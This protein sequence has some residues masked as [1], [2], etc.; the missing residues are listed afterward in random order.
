MNAG[1]YQITASGQSAQN[2][3]IS[4]Q[5]G[6]LTVGQAALTVTANNAGKTYDGLAFSGGNGVSYSGF[7]NGETAA[8]LA[9][10]IAYG[11]NAQ[12]AVNAG[13]YQITASGQSA[14]NYAIS[15]QPGTLTV[16]QVALTV[17]ANNAGKTYDGLAF[18]G[19]NGVSYSGFVNG[20]TATVLTGNIA[21]GGN[22]QGAVNA[23]GYQITAS[24]QSAQ[25][26]AISYQPGTLT[27]NQA[28]LTVTANNA[29][30]TY[31][32]LAFSGGNGVSYSGFVNGETAAVLAGTIAYAG[33]A[34]GA[35]NAG[36]YQI[37]ASGQSA[38]NYAISYQP[39]TLTVN[40]AALTVTAN[41]AGKTY[42][43]LAFSGGNGVSYSGFVNGETATVLAGTIAYAGNAQGAVN[44]GGY[45]I[46]ASGQSAQNYAISYQPGTLTVNQAALT[47]TA[48]NA[49]KTYDGLAFSGGNGVSYSGFVNGETAT[50][51]TGNI[52]YGGSAQGA[53]NAGGYQIT[54]SGQ[55]A[56][57]YAI[58]YQPGTLT[59]NQAA[60]TV[61]ANNAGKTYDG[62]AFSGGNGVSYSGFVNGE[63]AT[64]LAGT[65]AYAGNAQGAVNAGGYQITASGQSAQNYAISYQP[66]TLT[67]NQ[68]ALTV[69][70][71]NAGKTYDGLAFSGGNGVSYSGFVNGETATVLAGTIAYAGNAQGAVN[72]GGYQITASGQSAQNYAISYQPGTLTVNPAPVTVTALGGSS[73]YGGSPSDPGF[74]ATGLQNGQGVGALTGLGNSFGITNLTNAGGYVLNVA[75]TLTNPNYIVTVTNPGTWVVNP[76]TLTYVAN[77]AIAP[78]GA[79]IPTLG[80]VVVGFVNGDSL[81]AVAIGSPSFVTP[82]P[83]NAPGGIYP[84]D[85]QGL[86]VISSNY[87]LVQAPTNATALTINPGGNI[88]NTPTTEAQVLQNLIQNISLTPP[89]G[90]V[91]NIQPLT[92]PP[93]GRPGSGPPSAPGGLPPQFGARFFVPPELGAAH[94]DNEV[95][96]QIPNNIPA[97]QLQAMMRRLGLSILGSQSLGLLGVTSYWVHI[98]NGASIA[99][100]I[101]ALAGYQIVAGAQANYTYVLTQGQSLAQGQEPD[102]ASLSQGEGDAAQYTISK[103]GLIDVHRQLKGGNISVAVIDSQ[104]DVKHPDL[105][106]VVAEQFDAVGAADMPH[107]H[108]TGMAGAI[109]AHRKLMGVAP[110][111]RLYAIHAFSSGATSA[112]STTF[113]ILKGLEWASAKGV[114]VIN[115]SFAGPRDPSMERA[116]KAAHDKGIVLIAAAGNAGPKS[117]PLYPGADPNVI[118]V[119]AT[120]VND[121]LFTGA[122]RGRYIAVAA[123][124]VDILVPAPDNTY[125][126]TTGTSVASAE[127]SGLVALLLERNPNLGPEEVRK[128]LTSSA[129]RLSAKDRDDDFGSGLV[130]PSKAIQTAGDLTSVEM[131]GTVPPQPP[132][133]RPF[134]PARPAILSQPGGSG[135]RPMPTR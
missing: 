19:G 18:S 115:M 15:Y 45:Q 55:S 121:K 59:V 77:P 13:G 61:T 97:A 79:S 41:N 110:S 53:V 126:L 98:D 31:D 39:G 69:T 22:S 6:T 105:D 76:A 94:K 25:N 111:A 51:L 72:A 103:L 106:G 71:N 27:V 5:P 10:T 16:N 24:G 114:R 123:P 37:T 30:K 75:G 117:P 8:V 116:L 92:Q 40:Q 1:G 93:P 74:T 118:A 50:V 130:D 46:T 17:T 124:G 84:I 104:I 122:N 32:G 100:V 29:G 63:T 107:S 33:N 86:T 12:G 89:Q 44:A 113:N 95:V 43:G 38:Q 81:S 42:D 82:A 9:G 127:V 70:A 128:I 2:Y 132:A 56:Q 57:N 58:S 101:Q 21:Y 60:L 11:G 99:S 35:V 62:L 66:G 96:L 49:G 68:A 52:A 36:G 85:G 119:T 47:V 102:L 83:G 64:V 131:T 14:Q 91:V 112:E 67:V 78:S 88:G 34:Q 3:A 26:Y 4:Y 20:E 23:G 80:G 125:Q 7:V 135:A 28:A 134:T 129:R 90:D 54:A 133:L 120:D 108:G 87:V 73:T 65:I 109:F 48:N